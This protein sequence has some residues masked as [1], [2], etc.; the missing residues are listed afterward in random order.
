MAAD[1]FRAL[2]DR[3][4]L[5][6]ALLNATVQFNLVGQSDRGG[7]GPGRGR[8]LIEPDWP[9]WTRVAMSSPPAAS[10]T[11]LATLRGRVSDWPWPRS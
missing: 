2:G 5:F 3:E 4:L 9:C 11:G 8:A 7:N 6:A 10:T 1:T